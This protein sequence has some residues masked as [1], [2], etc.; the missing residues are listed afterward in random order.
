MLQKCMKNM[1][2]AAAI[3][4]PGLV[5]SSDANLSW[6]TQEFGIQ[7]IIDFDYK[8]DYLVT[9]NT[10]YGYFV[11]DNWE[12]GGILDINASGS[13]KNYGI[14][15]FTEYNF[16]NT[17]SLV[18]YV[19]LAAQFVSAK[20]DNNPKTIINEQLDTNAGQFKFALGLKYFINP[21]VAVS[22]EVNYTTATD[23]II[24]D[25][26]QLKKSFTRFLIGTRFYF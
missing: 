26:D 11:R 9:L 5:W 24:L 6:G 18:P 10:S 12:V 4:T 8:D 14:G 16:T 13:A 20:A 1:A 23:S 21:G 25:N 17:T 22:A 2:L 7:G 3:F 19:G 15:A